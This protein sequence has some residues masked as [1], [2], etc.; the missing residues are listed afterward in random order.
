[1]LTTKEICD[2]L[3]NHVVGQD[4][5][6]RAIALAYRERAL[7]TAFNSPKWRY[8]VPNN[9]L[10]IGPS[11]TGKT[12]LCKAMAEITGSPL[13][14][15]EITEYTQVGY[16]GRDVR[17]IL[18]DLLNEAIRIAPKLW[19][20]EM[21]G[22][23]DEATMA[24][25]RKCH[26]ADRELLANQLDVDKDKL[27]F[28]VFYDL[29]KAKKCNS[30]LVPEIWKVT[31]A[32]D[33]APGGDVFNN[34]ISEVL[35]LGSSVIN[36]ANQTASNLGAYAMMFTNRLMACNSE[37]KELLNE[38]LGKILPK[39]ILRRVVNRL[40]AVNNSTAPR[41]A[42]TLRASTAEE[43]AA[44]YDK[45][46]A[47][48]GGF[49]C[50]L[51]SILPTQKSAARDIPDSYI[52]KLVEERGI[53]FIDEFDKIFMDQDGGNV[54]NA[55][56]VRDIMPY[57]DGVVTEVSTST[58]RAGLFGSRGQTYR[59]DTSN[60]LWIASGAFNI[61]KVSDVP[62]EILG[63]LPVHVVMNP[64]T[65]DDLINVLNKPIGSVL[66]RFQLLMDAEGVNLV[67]TPEAVRAI[68]E[69]TF[70]C[71]EK[72]E[73]T[74]AR[75]L[76][77]ITTSLFNQILYDA[78]ANGV[79]DENATITIDEAF[80][81]NRHDEILASIQPRKER[82]QFVQTSEAALL[83]LLKAIADK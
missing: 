65:V 5:A 11:G 22:H 31:M 6:K 58:E 49:A 35:G 4:Q 40:A 46:S 60:I 26:A 10:M 38:R 53:V 62:A 21:G 28:E 80:V 20:E 43:L 27:T 2:L 56:V 64:L 68:A 29:Y 70:A 42:A 57:L 71:N 8:V 25:L 83:S 39:P 15:T 36:T 82:K 48:Y 9:I 51:K 61:A 33:S 34:A 69:L 14:K 76:T 37:D 78:S 13:I 12:Q 32:V 72:G 41:L 81:K 67:F 17:A 47:M 7:K 66:S 63:R 24:V 75:R 59:I 73:N 3:S 54:G 44:W 50:T 52:V 30:L 1:M 18:T 77:S 23:H 74:G 19:K 16:H 55:G 45:L 79:T